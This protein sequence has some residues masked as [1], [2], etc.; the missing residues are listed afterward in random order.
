MRDQELGI[1]NWSIILSGVPA[2]NPSEQQA[3]EMYFEYACNAFYMDHDGVYQQYKSFGISEAQ[4]AAWRREYIVFWIDRLSTDDLTAVNKLRD[5]WASE[6]LP[7]LIKIA[8]TGDDYA[9]L[10]YA[11]A[12]W[13]LACGTT[14]STAM[15]G[16]AIQTATRLWQSLTQRPI[17]ISASHQALIA[18]YMWALKASTPQEYVRN[19]ARGQLAEAETRGR[20]YA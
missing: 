4:E 2:M 8:D 16:L 12:I 7:E 14:I 17:K 1:R 3:K 10:W 9:A 13:R 18:P 20:L 5:A 19:Y 11:N 15:Q 6:A